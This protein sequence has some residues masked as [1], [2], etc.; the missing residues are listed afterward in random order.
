MTGRR[1]DQVEDAGDGWT[2][3]IQPV[4]SGYKMACC[5]CGLV[6]DLDFKAVRVKSKNDDGT[7]NFVELDDGR[8]RITMRVRRN[9]RSTAM[10]R[11]HRQ[12][13]VTAS[14]AT[15]GLTCTSPRA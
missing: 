6:H 14:P 11:R 10:V 13:K 15:G 4:M 12:N 5:D 1:Y 9:A 8:Y 7:W 2:T 3:W